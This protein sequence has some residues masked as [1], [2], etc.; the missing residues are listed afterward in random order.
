MYQIKVALFYTTPANNS[1]IYSCQIAST[2]LGFTLLIIW[3]AKELIK[4]KMSSLSYVVT[5]EELGN[6]FLECSKEIVVLDTKIIMH[7]KA[8]ESVMSAK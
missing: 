2:T 7:D 5:F 4:I 8:I 1:F 6:P 3:H